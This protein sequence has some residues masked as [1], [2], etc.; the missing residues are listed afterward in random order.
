M[1]EGGV[2][3]GGE[4]VGAVERGRAFVALDAVFL[5]GGDVVRV[6][7]CGPA[8][9]DERVAGA[10]EEGAGF[11]RVEDGFAPAPAGHGGCFARSDDDEELADAQGLD[12]DD[13]G[14][15][16]VGGVGLA[17]VEENGFGVLACALGFG[18]RGDGAADDV[19][20]GVVGL[21]GVVLDEVERAGPVGGAGRE[22][23]AHG[24]GTGGAEGAI[25]EADGVV[26][27]VDEG[28]E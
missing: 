24:G 6:G 3:V 8:E 11:G 9:D 25:G 18:G 10:G 13:V 23:V 16:G 1:G 2:D 22:G 17:D 12:V 21:A 27:E 5:L 19:P 14:G 20:E 4:G 28:V 15:P 7:V 26:G